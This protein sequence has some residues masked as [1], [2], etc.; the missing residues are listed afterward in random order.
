MRSLGKSSLQFILRHPWQFGLSVLGI[1][2]GVAV[3]TS[4]D[5]ATQSASTAFRLS[6]EAVSG[7]ATHH[8]LGP[9][10]GI[11]DSFYVTL[12]VRHG[13]TNIAPVIE[14]YA[15][16][17]DGSGRVFRMLGLDVFAE[18]PFRNYLSGATES[19][20]GALTRLMT[21]PGSLLISDGTLADLGISVRDS[22]PV[23]VNGV[24]HI[25]PIAGTLSD[26]QANAAALRDL[27][28]CDM[29]TAQELTGKRQ[30]IDFIDVLATNEQQLQDIEELLPPG[31]VLQ[32]SGARSR[33]ADQMLDAFEVN[34]FSLSLLALIVG[35]FLIYNTM[36]FSVVQR[37]TLI[38]TLRSIGVTGSE[39][40][41]LVLF[42]AVAVGSIG[43]LVGF[44]FAYFISTELI[45]AISR[46]I[47]DLYFVSSVQEVT[48][49]API[50]LKGLAL[51]VVGSALASL[52]PAREASAV[53]PRRAMMRS[54]QEATIQKSIPRMSLV[55]IASL[56]AGAAILLIPSRSIW[57][58][59]LGIL[60]IIIGFAL[61]TPR[62]I[63]L[64]E[65]L[66]TP[67]T[68]LLLGTTGKMS[69]RSVVRNLSRTYVSIAALALAVAATVGVGTMITSFR[70]TVLAW[71]EARLNGDI[72]VSAPNFVSRRNDMTVPEELLKSISSL[73][74]VQNVDYYRE[75]DVVQGGTPYM[76][77]AANLSPRGAA[78]FQFKEG[79]P[80]EVWKEFAAGR[81][82]VSE[83]FAFRHNLSIGSRIRLKTD[84]GMKEFTVAGICYDYATDQG[85]AFI[86][87]RHFR[88]DWDATGLS[89]ISVFVGDPSQIEAVRK[90]IQGLQIGGQQLLVSSY[91]DIRD[92]SIA[93]FD[94][95]FAIAWILQI[96]SVIVAFI[97]ILSSL[98]SLQL[99]RRRELGILRANGLV[100]SQL[101]SMVTLQTF[102]MGV[103]S[104]ILALPLGA[105]LA[106]ILVHII[107][108]RSFGWT[109]QLD[110]APS[111]MLEALL[112]SVV[113]ATFAGLYP[114]YKMSKASPASALR[115]E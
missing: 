64:L 108:K 30:R 78:G 85:L 102:L 2:M 58:G 20:Q 76:L 45:R 66:F 44:V 91:R 87:Y 22:L 70:S 105:I 1:A 29:A 98:M 7:K 9:A 61:L 77:L 17:N 95:T 103:A 86:D 83:P 41:R 113:A 100:P 106:A 19:L 109:M 59:Y 39:L 37:R 107:N 3:V 89:G 93:V 114:G 38:G 34:L 31:Y 8:I 48:I 79:R 25:L 82:V 16:L 92:N 42:E 21:S 46:T 115:E 28:I 97:G 50:V 56:A 11:P 72:F 27:L 96:L 53:H 84:H 6:M 15:R 5:I 4:I 71:L 51:G 110:L 112:L 111:I 24:P 81:L 43:T 74:G 62:A 90:R 10:E 69:S 57:L 80:D 14:T 23:V 33:S 49:T 36:T 104:A 55:G 63:I 12:R 40:S 101:F 35:L 47:N 54:E 75:F 32:R 73:D 68:T 52:K 18:R 94:R 88:Q 13:Y 26:D 65:R 60:P 67:L 99:E